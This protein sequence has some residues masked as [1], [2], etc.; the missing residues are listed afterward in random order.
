[1]SVPNVAENAAPRWIEVGAVRGAYGIKG[2]VRVAPYA[3]DALALRSA[4]LWRLQI[5]AGEPPREVQVETVRRHGAGLVAKW[6]GFD[7]PEQGESLRG[8]VIQVAR[9]SFPPLA[10]REAY[11]TDLI[12]AQVVS[13]GGAVLGQ[14]T[15]VRSNGVHDLME[16]EALSTISGRRGRTVLIPM[17]DSYVERIDAAA[18]VVH[19]DWDLSW[20]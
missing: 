20:S 13:R 17:V 6:V 4:K 12:G 2:W 9:A 18:G 14:V 1:M 16:V 10:E 19:V 5:A 7:L 11:W 8:A 15:G 3:D